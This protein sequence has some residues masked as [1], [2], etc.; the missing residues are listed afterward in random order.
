LATDA[1]S[2]TDLFDVV[3]ADRDAKAQPPAGGAL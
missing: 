2:S 3:P 1:K